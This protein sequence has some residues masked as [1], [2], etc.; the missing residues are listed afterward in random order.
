MSPVDPP[1]PVAL[2]I[3]TEYGPLP[4]TRA[5]GAQP[6]AD[7][8]G[9]R[10]TSEL[11]PSSATGIS[12]TER[13]RE[14]G[15]QRW[16]DRAD[17]AG[18]TIGFHSRVEEV[19]PLR[20]GQPPGAATQGHVTQELYGR[21][22]LQSKTLGMKAISSKDWASSTVV[23]ALSFKGDGCVGRTGA[24]TPDARG[25]FDRPLSTGR[26]SLDHNGGRSYVWGSRPRP[27]VPGSMSHARAQSS[28]ALAG[29]PTSAGRPRSVG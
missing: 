3:L 27:C 7:R 24:G 5:T 26:F 4:W 18:K 28:P 12:K 11:R 8:F 16:P 19:M 23:D 1:S 13:W 10:W 17:A 9:G 15:V 21:S 25:V 20:R 2:R 22:P 6:G 29:S 14:A